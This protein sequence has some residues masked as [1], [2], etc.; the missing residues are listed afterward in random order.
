MTG[1]RFP[2]VN[3]IL[4]PLFSDVTARSV[5]YPSLMRSPL[6]QKTPC[7]TFRVSEGHKGVWPFS[8]AFL[9]LGKA[10]QKDLQLA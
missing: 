10:L 7:W 1:P 6:E 9:W 5:G 4:E 2:W 8:E 3:P